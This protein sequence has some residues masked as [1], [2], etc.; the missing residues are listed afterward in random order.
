VA[1]EHV[2]HLTFDLGGLALELRPGAALGLTA[3]G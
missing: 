3:G 2:P 1:R